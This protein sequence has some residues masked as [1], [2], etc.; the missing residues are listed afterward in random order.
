MSNY[1]HVVFFEANNLTDG[2]MKKIRKYFQITRQSGGGECGE[3]EKLGENAYKIAFLEQTAQESVLHKTDHVV[4]LPGRGNLHILLSCNDIREDKKE[5]PH[6][7]AVQKMASGDNQVEKVLRLDPYLLRYLKDCPSAGSGLEKH[8]SLLSCTFKLDPDSGKVVVMKDTTSDKGD[9][10]DKQKWEAKVEKVFLEL[11]EN[12]CVH[13]VTELEII[14]LLQPQT[15]LSIKHVSVYKEEG[16]VVIVGESKEVERFMNVLDTLNMQQQACKECPMSEIKYAL[17]KEQ[18]EQETK[19]RFPRISIVQERPGSVILK[20]LQEQV[21]AAEAKLWELANQ[22]QERRINLHCA[23]TSFLASSDTAQRLQTH[24]Q[25]NLHSPVFLEATGSDLV[26]RSLSTG[27]LQQAAAVVER[28][29]CVETLLLEP[30]EAKSPGVETLKETLN[31]AVQRANQGGPQLDVR[32]KSGTNYDPRT[33]VL[34]VGYR[35]EVSKLKEIIQ[36]YKQNHVDFSDSLQLPLPE[37]VDTFSEILR[38]VG[39]KATNVKLQ[40][41]C[42]PD[43]CIHLS[44]PR[45]QV[46]DLK[47]NLHSV[48]SCLIWKRMTVNGPGALQFFQEEGA[49]TLALL[50]NSFQ[51]VI[52]FKSNVQHPAPVGRNRAGS[53]VADLP[54]T[55]SSPEDMPTGSSLALEIVFGGVEDQQVDVLV[56]PMLNTSLTSTSVGKCMLTKAGQQLKS[57][58]DAARGKC[59]ITPGDVVQLDGAPLGCRKVFFIECVPWNGAGNTSD[60]ALRCGLERVLA[61]CEQQGWGSVAMPVIG[62]GSPLSVPVHVATDILTKII[63]MFGRAGSTGSLS[64]IRIAI[65]PQTPDSERIFHEVSTGLSAQLVDPTGQAVFQSLSSE[66]DEVTITLGRCRLCLVLGDISNES[67]DVIVNTTDFIDLQTDVCTDILTVA[68]QQVKTDLTGARVSRGEIFTTQPGAFPC[69]VIMHV[70]GDK[71]AGIIKQLA[72]DI[73]SRCERDGHQ[74][75][76]IPAICAGK[77]GLDPRVVA[78]SILQGVR[79]ATVGSNFYHLKTIRIVLLKIHVF[80]EFK[81]MAQKIFGTQTPDASRGRQTPLFSLALSSLVQSLPVQQTMAEFL[82]VGLTENDMSDACVSLHQAYEGQCSSHSFSTDELKHLTAADVDHITNCAPSLGIETRQCNPDT[83]E[84]SGL[85]KGVNEM[86]RLIQGALVRQVKEKEKDSVFSSV[87]W[88]ILGSRGDWERLPREAHHQLE[89]QSVGGG[90]MDARGQRWTVSLTKME[91]TMVQSRQ[92]TKLKRL[93]NLSDFSFPLYWDSMGSGETV[94]LIPL[95]SS[96]AEYRRVKQGFKNT[97]SK[98]VLKVCCHRAR[99]KC[100]SP[101]GL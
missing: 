74:S 83:L 73:V 72:K 30:T 11:Q 85:T 54:T 46:K 62:P 100:T 29:L 68:G 96:S 77:G 37:M 66:T 99:S 56:A 24:V 33:E 82:I 61:L 75:V 44:G 31:Q 28:D 9:D 88:C 20:G 45:C 6:S 23:L 2:E 95:H 92:V 10:L 64:T 52:L 51:V 36:E 50:Q 5:L 87:N 81:A 49:N 25:L 17:V 34:L 35:T 41:T 89:S 1:K 71:N 80:L 79:D 7:S 42:S 15:F 40:A 3:V 65:L 78:E 94:K 70:C 32:Y 4:S 86:I 13:F 90:V 53:S 47:E 38:L 91:A 60:K 18:F 8:L 21:Q 67:T 39:V 19:L 76:A 69:K 14:R 55:G 93:V 48:I 63:G 97:V 26:L 22:I 27:A 101:P 59:K 84:V 43:P 12:Y 16:F 98:A 58:F 57:S